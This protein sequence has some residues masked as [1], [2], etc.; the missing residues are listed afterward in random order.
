MSYI[1][2]F[3]IFEDSMEKF[4]EFLRRNWQM[5]E[6]LFFYEN[7][8]LELCTGGFKN[9]IDVIKE[10]ENTMFWSMFFVEINGSVYKFRIQEKFLE[11]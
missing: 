10:L 3:N 6:W 8:V 1:S 11:R 4:I 5:D 2:E 7:G 9:N